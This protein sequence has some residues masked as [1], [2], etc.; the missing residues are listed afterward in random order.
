MSSIKIKI[1]FKVCLLLM[2]VTELEISL[3]KDAQIVAKF[4]SVNGKEISQYIWLKSGA[5]KVFLYY[6]K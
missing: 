2:Y 5:Y 1:R 6:L 4:R 3:F